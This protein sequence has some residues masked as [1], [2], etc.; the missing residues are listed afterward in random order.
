MK[1][2]LFMLNLAF[3]FSGLAASAQSYD[4]SDAQLENASFT[5]ASA[6]G[7]WRCVA[8]G[9]K[10]DVHHTSYSLRGDIKSTKDAAKADAIQTCHLY[11]LNNCQ[12]NGCFEQS[13]SDSN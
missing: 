2:S 13:E 7:L 3:L 6:Q 1:P 4:A 12:L 10:S 5:D 8:S 11:H 9:T